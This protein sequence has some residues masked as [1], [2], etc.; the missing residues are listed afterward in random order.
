MLTSEGHFRSFFLSHTCVPGMGVRASGLTEIVFT[1]GTQFNIFENQEFV[2]MTCWT[3]EATLFFWKEFLIASWWGPASSCLHHRL[4]WEGKLPHYNQIPLFLS[5][6]PYSENRW[7][8]QWRG[9][10]E[11]QKPQAGA[12]LLSFLGCIRTVAPELVRMRLAS[13]SVCE[14]VGIRSTHWENGLASLKPSFF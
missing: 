8:Y 13:L 7:E 1:C 14:G 3:L 2:W 9:L 5:I 10:S 4:T 6:L 11:A 12:S